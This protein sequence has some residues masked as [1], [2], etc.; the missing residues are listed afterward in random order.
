MSD[1]TL[2][3]P[4]ADLNTRLGRLFDDSWVRTLLPAEFEDGALAVDVAENDREVTVR[5]SVPGYKQEEIEVQV[6]AGILSIK[7]HH[8]EEKEEQGERYYRR[9]RFS[10]ALNRRLA[11]PGVV[12][13]GADVQAELDKG[14]LTIHIP[15]SEKAMPK[16]IEIKTAS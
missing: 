12:D 10:G 3:S 14:V 1:I 5:A 4:F 9:E 7:A 16:K 2:R 6:D 8:E 11:L 13:G 15:K